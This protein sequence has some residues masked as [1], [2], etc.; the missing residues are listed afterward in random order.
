M[1]YCLNPNCT[2][3]QNA[4]ES[5]FCQGC[6]GRLEPL[7]RDRYRIVRLLG[8]GAFGRTYL[9]EDAQRLSARC[10]IKQFLPQA[11]ANDKAI[12]LF[13]REAV[14][15]STL[16]EHPQIPTLIDYF[17]QV[18]TTP[19]KGLGAQLFI[20]Q[21]YIEGHD[22][23]RELQQGAFSEQQVREL[24]ADLLPVLK[25]IHSRQVIHRDI[26]PENIL[27][28]NLDGRLVLIDFG[29]AK[30]LGN[31]AP[32]TQGT[33][34]GTEGYAPVEQLRTG[35]AFPASDLYSLGV[36]CIHLLTNEPLDTLYNPL[37]GYWAWRE[38]LQKQGRAVS[39]QFGQLLEKLLK[40]KVDDRFPSAE[41][42]LQ[43]LEPL[44]ARPPVIMPQSSSSSTTAPATATTT[45]AP[46]TKAPSWQ[47]VAV[48]EGHSQAVTAIA[49]SPDGKTFAS[50]SQ[51]RT[52][53]LWKLGKRKPLIRI[54]EGHTAG[55]F[56]V[57]YSPDG[58]ILASAG[59]DKT[60]RLWRPRT[61]NLLRTL[62]GHTHLV[63]SIA[64]SPDGKLLLSGSYDKT[65]RLWKTSTG[66]LLRTFQGHSGSIFTVAFS[67]DGLF[68][69]S[70]SYD[71][72]VKLW[73]PMDGELLC[74]LKG[75]SAPV[76][77]I[78]FSPDGSILTS[79]GE[80][81]HLKP[82]DLTTS[83]PLCS[84]TA[85][86][87]A[88]LAIAHSPDQT[89]MATAGGDRLVKLWNFI[90]VRPIQSLKG[91]DKPVN[92]VVFS[93]DGEVVISGGQDTSVR[94]WRFQ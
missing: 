16:G 63:S 38:R 2:K 61:G 43:A 25:F 21:E 9:A 82:W 53:R 84:R 50:A 31:V 77:A 6:G 68:V 23:L 69:A 1:S 72:T 20:V 91:H 74:T 65:L 29:V 81:K 3:P 39:F 87:A 49:V 93:P 89:M 73:N 42:V 88:V 18:E 33:K 10:V 4:D 59:Q 90:T 7:L 47:C 35:Q 79:V 75:H 51:D 54:L 78:A 66:K 56:G 8:Q 83:K 85:H 14:Q 37:R 12:A 17:E 57:A 64:F 67:P 24:L 5:R 46:A 19:G 58:R 11:D 44:L 40:E 30:E 13:E 22:L 26:K 32:H 36:T 45:A 34:V 92:A 71:R 76:M 27:R 41:A 62:T 86:P 55:V 15:L 28:R 70:G 52:L 80:D 48:L 94:L 60:I